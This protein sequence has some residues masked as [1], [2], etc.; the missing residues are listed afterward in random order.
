MSRSR[1]ISAAFLLSGVAGLIYEVLWSRY[2]A[3]FV[4]HGAYAQVLVLTVYLGGMA[5][6]ALAV[7]R[8]C[9]T[10]AN[11]LR[12]YVGAELILGIFGLAFHSVF[13]LV[14]GASYDVLFPAIG[15]PHPREMTLDAAYALRAPFPCRSLPK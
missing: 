5:V 1:I 7:S 6:G 3:L 14:T 2:L 4:G 9:E 8:V 10:T 12:W 13:Q 15:T 11:P